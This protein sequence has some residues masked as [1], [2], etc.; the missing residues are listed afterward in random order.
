MFML[1]LN[2]W[3]LWFE[4]VILSQHIFDSFLDGTC[5][6]GDWP[7]WCGQGWKSFLPRIYSGHEIQEMKEVFHAC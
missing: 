4:P 5:Q 3:L 2:N 1:W 7:T 6:R